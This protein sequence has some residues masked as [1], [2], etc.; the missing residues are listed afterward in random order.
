MRRTLLCLG[1]SFV[2]ANSV[3]IQASAQ[4]RPLALED[5]YRVK[6]VGDLQISPDAEWVAYTVSVRIEKTNET[7]TESWIVRADG[8]GEPTRVQ[9]TGADVADPEWAE[10]GRL[11]F[12]HQEASW[13]VDPARP[14]TVVG[15]VSRIRFQHAHC[16]ES[17]LHSLRKPCQAAPMLKRHPHSVFCHELPWEVGA[18]HFATRQHLHDH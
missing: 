15:C 9:H 4:G 14:R 5:Y 10:D 16:H 7:E 1:L 17:V 8:S 2:G 13:L 18:N 11:R 6:T 12:T 3:A